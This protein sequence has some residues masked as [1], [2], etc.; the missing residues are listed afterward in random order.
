MTFACAPSYDDTRINWTKRDGMAAT[1]T[2]L[3]DQLD[4]L[5]HYPSWTDTRHSRNYM[6]LAAICIVPE[7]ILIRCQIR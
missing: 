5:N 2:H 6:C 4:T 3:S 7:I 1:K